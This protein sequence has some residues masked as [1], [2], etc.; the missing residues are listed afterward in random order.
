MKIHLI[1]PV[2]KISEEVDKMLDDYVVELESK[3]HTV[4][5]PKR[6]VCQDDDGIGL[7]ICQHHLTN[8]KSADEVHIL[9][10][11]DSKGSHFDFGM[12]FAMDKTIRLIQQH[13]RVDHK[14]YGNVLLT[15]QSK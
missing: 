14:S 1:C 3:G 6:D 15:I 11:A 8:M 9:W 7:S 12:A 5:Y 4:H 13:D 2:R 10:D